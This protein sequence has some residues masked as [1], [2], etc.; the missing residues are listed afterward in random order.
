MEIAWSSPQ[1]RKPAKWRIAIDL[2]GCDSAPAELFQGVLLAGM[3]SSDALQ[4][5]AIA[6][7]QVCAQ[8]VELAERHTIPGHL[9]LAVAQEAIAMAEVPT[10]AVCRKPKATLTVG[11]QLLKDRTVDALISAGNSGAIIS[12]ARLSLPPLPG[13][14]RPAL[15]ALLPTAGKMVALVDAGG[16]LKNNSAT[17]LQHAQMGI[18]YQRCF[19]GIAMP[20]VGL[21]NIGIEPSKGTLPLK[22][23]YAALTAH[24]KLSAHSERGFTFVGNVEA[25]DLFEGHVDIIVADG[26][27]GNVL[28][29]AVEG[30]ALFLLNTLRGQLPPHSSLEAIHSRFNYA[31]SS[32]ALVCGVDGVVIKCHG[33]AQGAAI[34]R[35]VADAIAMVDKGLIAAISHEL[36]LEQHPEDMGGSL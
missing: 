31:E 5:T 34:A 2:M 14:R 23:A 6:T 24:A 13:I 28:L 3:R 29:K 17:L 35:A 4:L 16:N 8:L 1:R 36:S 27:T 33:N 21:L 11:M 20:A 12:S 32:G 22:E 9:Q 7:A 26:F 25:R 10:A 18:A 30:T 15:L 19:G